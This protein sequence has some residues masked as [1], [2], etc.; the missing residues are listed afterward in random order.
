MPCYGRAVMMSQNGRR[1][2]VTGA[3]GWLGG[4][5]AARLV[6][7]GAVVTALVRRR[8]EVRGN[9]GRLVPVAR[10]LAGDI[11]APLLGW[12]PAAWAEEA[13]GFDLIVHC[14]ALTQFTAEPELA[15]AVNVTGSE[16]VAAL[17]AAGSGR[18]LHVSTA[19][20]NGGRDGIVLES[21]A[22][23]GPFTNTYEASKAEAEQVVRRPDLQTVIA[24]P[25]IVLGEWATGAV[26][27]FGTFYYLLKA[28]ADGWV[29]R[30]PAD[31]AATLDMV[32][33]D[34]VVAGIMALIE[35]FEPAAGGTFHLVS[36]APT[37]MQAFP[38]TLARFP[39][40][41]VPVFVRPD[42]MA[43]QGRAFTRLI[44]PY[45]PYFLRNPRFDDRE[46]RRLTG[47]SCPPTDA[48]WWERLV[49]FA[50][51]AGFIG[52]AQASRTGRNG[53]AS[54]APT[55]SSAGSR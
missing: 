41:A 30:M 28:L 16:T 23:V 46:F 12:T 26:R 7:S 11:A 45:A 22:P 14:A 13:G 55:P 35:R 52:A 51:E 34:H 5:V 17:A 20:V 31:P 48:G 24:R 54:D 2:L 10:T 9:D 50:L 6:A 21:D 44:A 3:G 32:P 49:A 15:H 18:L 19:Y 33:V 27:E 1:V 42:E 36:G 8:A 29:K 47:S 53:I 4:E 40:L 25:S 39:G 38:D 43:P 37:P